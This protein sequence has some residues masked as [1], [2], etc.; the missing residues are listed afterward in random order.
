LF[1]SPRTFAGFVITI[2]CLKSSFASLVRPKPES[3][4]HKHER[5]LTE[6]AI[7]SHCSQLKLRSGRS[8]NVK[9]IA[10]SHFLGDDGAGRKSDFT[11]WNP[12]EWR[13]A[14]NWLLKALKRSDRERSDRRLGPEE[15]RWHTVFELDPEG[16]TGVRAYIE[17][18]RRG[19]NSRSI[20]RHDED[21][22][23]PL[24]RKNS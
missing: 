20:D 15:A 5:P 2:P 18:F 7:A 1:A 4:T 24:Y 21:R 22:T 17:G 3:P 12:A 6:A 11:K 19:V 10:D 23:A 8:S 9:Q 13:V 16:K 14:T